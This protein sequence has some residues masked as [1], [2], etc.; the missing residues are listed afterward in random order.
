MVFIESYR[1]ADAL[2]SVHLV[3]VYC[4]WNIS[5]HCA[6]SKKKKNV[7][8]AV[9]RMRSVCNIRIIIESIEQTPMSE[10]CLCI[11]VDC[12]NKILWNFSLGEWIQRWTRQQQQRPLCL[13][14]NSKSTIYVFLI[15]YIESNLVKILSIVFYFSHLFG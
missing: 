4:C 9:C 2:C 1:W 6:V 15:S 13:K 7:F 14:F 3:M 8:T 12:G 11:L 5:F 10:H